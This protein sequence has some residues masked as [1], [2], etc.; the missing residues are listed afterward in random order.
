MDPRCA[1]MILLGKTS[2][3]APRHL[4]NSMILVPMATAGVN[5]VRSLN[6]FGYGN[7]CVMGARWVYNLRTTANIPSRVFIPVS[8]TTMRP[9]D[10]RKWRW[11]MYEFQLPI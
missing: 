9:T 10:T 5:I 7:W 8:G 11:W 3:T 6:V 1:V 4:Q 2:T